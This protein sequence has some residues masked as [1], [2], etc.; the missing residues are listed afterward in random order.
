M[1]FIPVAYSAIS[2]ED[3]DYDVSGDNDKL[4]LLH[5]QTSYTIRMEQR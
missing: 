5:V 2:E 3:T 1:T 4:G